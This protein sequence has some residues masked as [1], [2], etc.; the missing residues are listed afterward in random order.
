METTVPRKSIV[1]PGQYA[2]GQIYFP[3]T[4]AARRL[5]V[6]VFYNERPVTFDFTQKPSDH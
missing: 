5:R 6:V 2:L 1:G 3:R 4:D